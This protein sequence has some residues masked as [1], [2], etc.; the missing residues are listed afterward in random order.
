M[1]RARILR[2]RR[3]FLAARWRGGDA[4][5]DGTLCAQARTSRRTSADR[6]RRAV[7]P[8]PRSAH[9]HAGMRESTAAAPRT[10]A[11]PRRR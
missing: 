1:R 8:P 11:R 6:A 5:D 2:V 9:A 10:G 7:R 4:A 3:F